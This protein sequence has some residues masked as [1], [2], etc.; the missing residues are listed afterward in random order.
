MKRNH[1]LRVKLSKEELEMIKKKSDRL[2]MKPS[3]FLRFLGLKSTI[4]VSL[5]E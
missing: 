2:G 4:S 3:P 1:E 5:E